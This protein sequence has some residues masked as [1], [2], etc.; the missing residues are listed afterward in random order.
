MCGFVGFTNKIN[1]NGRVLGKMMDRIIHRGPDASGSFINGDIALGF[2]R[3]SIIDLAEG[4][5]PMF[6]EDKSLVLVFNGEIY[7]YR[8]LRAELSQNGHTFANNSDSEVL[9]HGYE[10][11]GTELV[12]KL[13]GM[14]AFVIFNLKSKE[15]FAARDMFG[16]KP[17]YYAFMGGSLL[18]ASEIKAFQEHPDFRKEL[19][20]EA[21]GHYLSFQYS[22]L[23]ETFFKNVYK[24][25]PAHYMLFKDGKL[26]TF[27][28][29][30][31]EFNGQ[32][33]SLEYFTDMTDKTVRE[34]VAAHKI[35]DVEVGAFLSGGIDSS[36]IAEA[37]DVD[38]TF[39]VGFADT[40]GRNYNEIASAK[41][42]AKA[43]KT[44][45]IDKVITAEEYWSEFAKIQY[46]MDEPLADPSAIALYFVSKLASKYVKVV[47]SGEGAD[48]LFGGYRIYQEPIT[49]T[50]YDK[51][52]MGIRRT[53]SRLCEN[54]PPKRGINY[55]VRRGKSVEE[56][57]IG[58][59]KIFSRKERNEILKSE[60][61]KNAPEPSAVCAKYYSEVKDKDVITK[62]QYL[63]INMWLA[64]DILLK[65]DKTSMANSLELRVPFLDREV[66]KLASAIPTEHRV[67]VSTTKI[68]LRK[69]ASKK[70]PKATAERDKLGF[71]IPI[72]VWLREDKY[73]NIVKDAFTSDISRR[74]FHT[75]KI[76]ALLDLHKS[77]KA[78]V[79]R[80]IWTIYTFIVWYR[81][82]FDDT[83]IPAA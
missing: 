44:E 18:F 3:L 28:Y 75:D 1:D 79:S 7:N 32:T 51:L 4:N 73:Y 33:G 39:T 63:D 77:G 36:Y 35:A 78:D 38:K 80:K 54:F 42:F 37:A 22:P 74:F 70:L 53:V 17:L 8:E 48:E 50:A 21:L 64:G 24:L 13:R 25:L 12:N 27:R 59:A 56:Y 67:N 16:I 58:N 49:L 23:E 55:L 46:H 62:L 57:Y 30:K 2:R 34:S 20:E 83:D 5:Q 14:F 76:V 81:Q 11:W 66:M 82:F 71:P 40:D 69:A 47:M 72:R 60:I 41:E 65:A 29:W 68:A 61:A 31:P 15:L 10:Q 43:I 45:N 52:P 6:N 26:E 19:N 9:L